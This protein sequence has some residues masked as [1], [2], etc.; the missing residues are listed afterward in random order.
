ML[1]LDNAATSYRKP[2]C[3]YD[4]MF[5]N[6]LENSV[7]AGHGGHSYSLRGAAEIL[8]TSEKLCQLF[9][10]ANPE[11]IAYTQNATYALNMAIGGILQ[12]G[13]HAVITQMEHNSVLRPVHHYG[14]YTIVPADQ[15]GFVSPTAV[16]AAIQPDTALIVC[17]PVS[18]VCGT[19]QPIAEIGHIARKHGIIFLVDAAQSAGCMDL[20]V[21]A[22]QIDLLAFSGHKGLLAP[23]GIGGLYVAEHVQ[24]TPILFGGT[25]SYAEQLEQPDFMP[26]L[27]Q[28]GTQNT[29]AIIA[30]GSAV[31][32]IMRRTPAAIGLHERRLAEKLIEKLLNMPRLTVYGLTAGSGRN[33]TVAFNIDGLDSVDV[34]AQLN[35]FYQICVR[36]GWHCAYGAHS[37]LGSASSGAVRASFGAFDTMH[38][39]NDLADAVYKIAKQNA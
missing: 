2:T 30:L 13:G 29:P 10:I 39:V 32:Y 17:T 34:T 14:N 9:S 22:M 8:K 37:A 7:N 25:G 6:T 20:D 19:V 4:S 23:L 1:Y 24:L 12:L 36:G 3:V 11:R 18:N 38:A 21:D 35:D 16:E 31:D 5:K 33:G 26:D 27:L 15:T 28:S